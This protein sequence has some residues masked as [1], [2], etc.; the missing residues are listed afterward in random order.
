MILIF[1]LVAIIFFIAGYAVRTIVENLNY[2]RKY[3]RTDN[4]F[5]VNEYVRIN[6]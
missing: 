3:V 1:C 2:R 4:P 6:K 5:A